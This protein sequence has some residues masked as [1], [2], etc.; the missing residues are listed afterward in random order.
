VDEEVVTGKDDLMLGYLVKQDLYDLSVDDLK[1]RISA[2]EAEITRCK[3]LIE[4]R[5]N[6]KAAAENLF[7]T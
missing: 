6:I 2:M 1:E 5:G 4:T 3:K 7:K